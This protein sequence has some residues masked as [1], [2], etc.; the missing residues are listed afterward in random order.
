M[1][2][3]FSNS[4]KKNMTELITVHD[5]IIFLLSFGTFIIQ[6]W[7]AA[8]Q[9]GTAINLVKHVNIFL[10]QVGINVWAAWWHLRELSQQ[11]WQSNNI[12]ALCILW[13]NLDEDSFDMLWKII[14]EQPSRYERPMYHRPIWT[15]HM[16][17]ST[18]KNF[19]IFLFDF[20]RFR[21]ESQ[22][23][24]LT[25]TVSTTQSHNDVIQ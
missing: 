13:Q 16:L 8:Q 7:M 22:F 18:D 25:R 5:S 24:F 6:L 2:P 19:M 17:T 15:K 14:A 11:T 12:H 4:K 9:S 10:L 1:T 20:E 21:I 3:I 23:P